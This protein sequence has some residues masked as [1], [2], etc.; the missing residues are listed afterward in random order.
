MYG[1]NRSSQYGDSYF[2]FFSLAAA[3][4][5]SATKTYH[6]H[7]QFTMLPLPCSSCFSDH[8]LPP[9]PMTE[10]PYPLEG[11]LDFRNKRLLNVQSRPVRSFYSSVYEDC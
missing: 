1:R 4:P 3:A 6:S 5:M 10:F 11:C 2:L 9:S 8:L 7:V